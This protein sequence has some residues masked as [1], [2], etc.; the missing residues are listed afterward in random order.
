VRRLWIL[1]LVV[2]T[3]VVL[4]SS[5]VSAQEATPAAAS[6]RE[7]FVVSP[8]ECVINTLLPGVLNALATPAAEATPAADAAATPAGDSGETP[9]A[10][11]GGDPADAETATAVTA[12]F[13]QAVACENAGNLARYFS[14]LTE[15]ELRGRFSP[16]DVANAMAAPGRELPAEEQTAL[17]AILDVNIHEDGRVG[18]FLVVDTVENPDPVEVVYMIATETVAGWRIDDIITFDREGSRR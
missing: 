7:E 13:R 6:A 8:A 1:S 16:E 14:L 9:F 10:V 5:A 4:G 3:L 12:I 15:G 11:P 17:Y 18:A 2:G